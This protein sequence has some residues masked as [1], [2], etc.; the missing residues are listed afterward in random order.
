MS[1]MICQSDDL[2]HTHPYG[3]NDVAPDPQRI[4]VCT[5]CGHIF[6]DTEI[7][8]DTGWGHLCKQH[9]CGKEPR[10]ESHLGPYIP[11][12]DQLSKS[13]LSKVGDREKR[14]LILAKFRHY[15]A[16]QQ[17]DTIPDS[18]KVLTLDSVVDYILSLFHS[19]A[20]A[21]DREKIAKLVEQPTLND[22]GLVN[23]VDYN[24]YLA[25]LDKYY[26]ELPDLVLATFRSEDEVRAEERKNTAKQIIEAYDAMLDG[27]GLGKNNF[28]KSDWDYVQ[29]LKERS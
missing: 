14:V 27:M 1:K 3:I 21:G 4:W 26:E 15:Q 25:Y 2:N 18:E 17:M 29:S 7:R 13:Q 23:G 20:M 22:L 5:E 12:L 6:N 19:K 11:E 9:P 8:E 16:Q 24:T 10:C 28:K